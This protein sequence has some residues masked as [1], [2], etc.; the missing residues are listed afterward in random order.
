MTLSTHTTRVLDAAKVLRMAQLERLAKELARPSGEH[1]THDARARDIAART[2]RV[3][4]EHDLACRRVG[5]ATT[6]A[7]LAL[8][9]ADVRRF[10]R[11]MLLGYASATDGAR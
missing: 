2:W 5:A 7:E 1:G 6:D 10:E 8:A 4:V 9:R 11:V 3:D